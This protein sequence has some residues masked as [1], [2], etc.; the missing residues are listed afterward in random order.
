MFV[1]MREN[2][3]DEDLSRA[4]SIA[5]DSGGSLAHY[6]DIGG[7]KVLRL[8]DCNV[9]TAESIGAL[10]A[11]ERVLDPPAGAPL[12]SHDLVGGAST[13][14]AAGISVGTGDFTV[15]A[16]PCAVE[17]PAQLRLS[18][19]AVRSAGAVVLRGGAYKPRT[20]PYSFQGVGREGL[21]YLL[22]A[23]RQTGLPIV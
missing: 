17:N 8:P 12:A 22:E 21:D 1:V 6:C 23:K 9:E 20:S 14:T 11:V 7:R 10:A 18:A 15:I 13:V 16:G 19:A 5:T 4:R 3:S 2:V